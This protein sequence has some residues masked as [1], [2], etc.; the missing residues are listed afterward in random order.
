MAAGVPLITPIRNTAI[1]KVLDGDE[2]VF[3]S[4]LT[5][6]ADYVR[7]LERLLDEPA[8]A[9]TRSDRMVEKSGHYSTERYAHEMLEVLELTTGHP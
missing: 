7:A 2:A 1:H 5:A 9:R 4:D 3:V 8:A 6:P